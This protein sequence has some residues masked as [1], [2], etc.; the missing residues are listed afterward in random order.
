MTKEE[1][2]KSLFEQIPLFSQM[3]RKMFFSQDGLEIVLTI[4]GIKIQHISPSGRYTAKVHSVKQYGEV[5][6][7][8]KQRML[9][10]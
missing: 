8:I 7:Q 6:Y 9:K 2:V 3:E 4:D 1:R 10:A 5:L